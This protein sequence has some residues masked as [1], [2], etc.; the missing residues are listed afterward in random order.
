LAQFAPLYAARMKSLKPLLIEAMTHKW[1]GAGVQIHSR[2]AALSEVT[3]P[4][5]AVAVVGTL[6]KVM[7][8][9][10][11]ALQF[12]SDDKFSQAAAD[13]LAAL[14]DPHRRFWSADD[15]LELEDETSRIPV[16]LAAPTVGEDPALD[17]Q[18]DRLVTGVVIGFRGHVSD[19]G[20]LLADEICFPEAPPLPAQLGPPSGRASSPPPVLALVSGLSLVETPD[21][22]RA[23]LLVDY[24]TGV[25]GGAADHQW[26]AQ[27][28]RT[29]VLG[30]TFQGRSLALDLLEQRL[31][32]VDRLLAELS[33]CMEVDILPSATDPS[34]LQFPVH[35]F[36]P[37]LFPQASQLATFHV[38]GNPHKCVVD[39]YPLLF[40]SG[41]V[42][43]SLTRCC[44]ITDPLELLQLLLRWRHL[45][46]V[47]PDVHPCQPF[48]DR[49]PFLLAASP[50]L[51]AIG[52][53]DRFQWRRW[54]LP[55]DP[56]GR[57]VLLV[58]VPSF[59]KTGEAVIVDLARQECHA[60]K[61]EHPLPVPVTGPTAT[62]S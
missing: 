37:C 15:T 12:Y 4:T 36:N 7:P 6:I 35:P 56:A 32:T 26:Q 17:L 54:P 50:A 11:T 1:S 38:V 39:G 48:S 23:G 3:D 45:V 58:A 33:A 49:D 46:P 14:N 62:S 24:L 52:G 20:I 29:I 40:E 18:L 51:F 2:I 9:K 28:V 19:D 59:E 21:L 16:R 43:T 61:I 57:S 8:H 25:L 55:G 30:G 31:P 34:N 27:L 42:I 10:P 60:L 22:L 47:A 41:D 44:S 13:A 5:V 53:A